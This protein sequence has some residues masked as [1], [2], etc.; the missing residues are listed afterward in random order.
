MLLLASGPVLGAAAGGP[1]CGVLC[2]EWHLDAAA[3]DSRKQVLDT[4]FEKFK[5]P[6]PRQRPPPPPPDA[7]VAVVGAILDE[8]S[9]RP[10]LTRLPRDELR[11]ELQQLMRQPA[12]LTLTASGKNIRVASSTGPGDR[13]TPGEP[14]TRV[15]R[16]GTAR[17]STS[18]KGPKL[19][20]VEKYDR[21]NVQ[22]TTFSLRSND[23]ALEVLQVITRSGLPKVSFRSVYRNTAQRGLESGS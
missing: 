15:D 18:W 8:E 13:L 23:G 6:K 20:V 9:L 14:H 17:I 11:D 12:S 1:A 22:E 21:K 2:G 19:V 10:T 4:A 16:Y 7:D 3:S 5:D